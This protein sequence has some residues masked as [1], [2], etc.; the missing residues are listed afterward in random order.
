LKS[1]IEHVKAR[2]TVQV[3]LKHEGLN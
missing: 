3:A 2:P 1:F